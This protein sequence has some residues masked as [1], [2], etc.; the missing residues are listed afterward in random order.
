VHCYTTSVENL[1]CG[2]QLL[3]Y[4]VFCSVHIHWSSVSWVLPFE[5]PS[6]LI[7]I[8]PSLSFSFQEFTVIPSYSVFN[9]SCKHLLLLRIKGKHFRF[10][11]SIPR[12]CCWKN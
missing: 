7:M 12:H 5:G 6:P 10:K 2:L 8:F 9:S 3:R 4:E 11:N 1:V